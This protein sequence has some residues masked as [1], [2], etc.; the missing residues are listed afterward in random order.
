[1]KLTF[2]QTID[3]VVDMSKHNMKSKRSLLIGGVMFLLIIG[4]IAIGTSTYD[5]VDF[6]AAI[7]SAL[8]PILFMIIFWLVFIKFFMKKSILWFGNKDLM[9][10]E[11]IIG[12]LEDKVTVWTPQSEGS[13]QWET[14]KELKQS[15]KNYFLFISKVQAILISKRAFDNESQ[16]MEFEQLVNS[17]ISNIKK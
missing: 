16:Q 11:R 5:G 3:D 7:L 9:V 12:I 8:L 4:Y 6:K 1:M 15:G 10:G 17:K 2:N 13:Y 14:I